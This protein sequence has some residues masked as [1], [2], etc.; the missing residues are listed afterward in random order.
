MREFPEMGKSQV[1]KLYK[2]VVVLI[3]SLKDN[4]D[5]KLF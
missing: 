2:L 1:V 3:H 4:Y 5:D